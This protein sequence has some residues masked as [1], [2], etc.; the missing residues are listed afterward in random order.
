MEKK[1]FIVRLMK[2]EKW[3]GGF[4][5]MDLSWEVPFTEFSKVVDYLSQFQIR[6]K[7]PKRNN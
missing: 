5:N 2:K 4:M 6:A 3:E 7:R 1:I